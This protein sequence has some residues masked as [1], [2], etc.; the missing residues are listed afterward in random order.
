MD[1]TNLVSQK[2]TRQEALKILLEQPD[3][4]PDIQVVKDELVI[5]LRELKQLVDEFESR[6]SYILEKIVTGESKTKKIES[7]MIKFSNQA[8]LKSNG[9][10]IDTEAIYFNDIRVGYF[11]QNQIYLYFNRQEYAE[12]IVKILNQSVI[13]DSREI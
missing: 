10:R 5:G 11:F 3:C 12:K 4:H 8:L 7:S 1:L 6:K 2:I 9:Y 13:I